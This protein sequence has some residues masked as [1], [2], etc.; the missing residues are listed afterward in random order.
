MA[1]STLIASARSHLGI[2]FSRYPALFLALSSRYLRA[3]FEF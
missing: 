1:C 2:L 3:I